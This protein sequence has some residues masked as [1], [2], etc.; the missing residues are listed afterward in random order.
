MYNAHVL[1]RLTKVLAVWSS[2]TAEP[3]V[4][5]VAQFVDFVRYGPRQ[6]GLWLVRW[7]ATNILLVVQRL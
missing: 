6:T 4:K 2:H 7:I 5:S 1:S 3:I